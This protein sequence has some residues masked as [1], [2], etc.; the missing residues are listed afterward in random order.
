MTTDTLTAEQA[1]LRMRVVAGD[2]DCPAGLVTK[3]TNAVLV[4]REGLVPAAVVALL[5]APARRRAGA[6]RRG[7]R[8]TDPSASQRPAQRY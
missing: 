5:D 2:I 3:A 6:T 8:L 7:A 1:Q 4:L